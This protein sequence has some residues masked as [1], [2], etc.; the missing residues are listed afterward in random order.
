MFAKHKHIYLQVLLKGN[1]QT[2]IIS[3]THVLFLGLTVGEC[4]CMGLMGNFPG[5]C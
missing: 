4:E 5:F 1:H 3:A 2:L